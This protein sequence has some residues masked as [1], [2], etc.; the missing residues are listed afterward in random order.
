MEIFYVTT[1]AHKVTEAKRVLSDFKI[2]AADSG[3]PCEDAPDFEGNALIKARA[4][5][6]EG[7]FL[8]L[9]EDS[10]LEVEALSGAPGVYSKRYGPTPAERIARLLAE[11]NGKDDRRAAFVAVTV[12]MRQDGLAHT[13]VGRCE[14]AI[15]LTPRGTSGFG[16]DPVFCP[17]G[18]Q[19]TFAEMNGDEK[20]RYSH[21]AKSLHAVRE[22]LE[23]REGQRFAQGAR[24]H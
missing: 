16:Y 10:G 13:F 20:D 2:V 6:H 15:A 11:L 18:E 5:R 19:R 9:A 1:N 21:R 23:S 8:V 3:N 14:G 17:L 12:L 24:T 4:F 7:A 22:F